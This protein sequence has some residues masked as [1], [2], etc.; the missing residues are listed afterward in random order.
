M[1]ARKSRHLR[2]ITFTMLAAVLT[3]MTG[4]N[5]NASGGGRD[6]QQEADRAAEQAA[7]T[8]ERASRDAAEA[9]ER[10]T[11]AAAEVEQRAARGAADSA[12]RTA[13]VEQRFAEETAKAAADAASD[14]AKAS[15][16]LA[17]AEADR[18]KAL[19]DISVSS[20]NS[21]TGSSGSD[22]SGSSGSTDDPSGSGSSG[23]GGS[24]DGGNSISLRDLA[25][26][27]NPDF[28]SGGFPVRRGEVVALDFGEAGLVKAK[29]DGFR[30][31]A[32]DRLEA[33]SGS[34]TR[35]NTPD[36]LAPEAALAKLRAI[37]PSA[38][39]DYT[40]YY[41]LQLAP[42]GTV[43]RGNAADLARRRGDF[44][45]GMIDTGVGQHPFLAKTAIIQRRFGSGNNGSPMVDHG[46]AV[47]SILASDGS[48]QLLV[49][50]VF[51]GSP[52]LPFT[53]ADALVQSLEW[54]AERRVAVVNI[55]LAG[56]RNA[57][58]DRLI[59]RASAKGMVVVA[60]AG[61]GG[62]TAPPAYPAALG[63]VVAVTAV[64]AASH[65]YRYA[66]QGSY[67]AVAARG[68]SEP[69]ARAAGGI[70]RF[71]GTSFATPHI[72]AWMAR[73][74]S[75]KRATAALCRDSL[76]IAARDAGTPGRDPVYGWGIVDRH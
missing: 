24:S 23:N 48:R 47:A 38:T 70:A 62:P 71:S 39:F 3:S 66:N 30:V 5:L 10:S 68:V 20:S 41:G 33:L 12:D 34:V 35:L 18:A 29:S 13:K 15:E 61:N 17:K 25:R 57:I 67:I 26:Q 11:R 54:M 73:C 65:V 14:P 9:L 19:A 51:R 49:A 31:I 4:S 75:Q 27:E 76:R 37:D 52:T 1:V 74:L 6:P 72:S 16:D 53:S 58:L 32:R 55:S 7:R 56:P 43:E 50:D 59:E 36:G 69:A 40:H 42:Q 28:D 8:Q 21:G 2:T 44:T 46:T 63:S 60:A 64:D 22:S 45:T